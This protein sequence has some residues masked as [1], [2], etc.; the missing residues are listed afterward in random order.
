LDWGIGMDLVKI[1][2][3]KLIRKRQCKCHFGNDDIIIDNFRLNSVNIIPENISNNLEIDFYLNTGKDIYL[4]R[5]QNKHE[6]KI[7]FI[8]K[9]NKKITL[10]TYIIVRKT[11]GTNINKELLIIINIL[12]SINFPKY[13]EE[14]IFDINEWK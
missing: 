9:H 7:F 14:K 11:F 4:L 13:Y 2:F 10:L 12:K 1:L 5:L 6:N 8:N 3:G